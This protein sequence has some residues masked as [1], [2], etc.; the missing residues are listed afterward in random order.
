M[1]NT[2]LL[3]KELQSDG[4]PVP[5]CEI[6]TNGFTRWGHN[7]HMWCCNINDNGWVFG[8]WKTGQHWVIFD[9]TESKPLSKEEKRR[10]AE[11]IEAQKQE[12]QKRTI[13]R[14]QRVATQQ[15]NFYTNCC[16][17]DVP[18][19]FPYLVKKQIKPVYGM[20]YFAIKKQI[21]VPMV[22]V[23]G[24]MWSLQSIDT[25]GGKQFASGGRIKGCFF[26][27]GNIKD[28]TITIVC[29]G[30]AT[31]ISIYT[32]TNIPTIAAM[33]AGNIDSVVSELTKSCSCKQI[34]IAGD[35][36]WEKIPNTGKETAYKV[37][38]KY[39]LKAVLPNKLLSGMSDFNDVFC[40][41]GIEEVK[42]Q[43][44]KGKKTC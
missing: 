6:K 23:Y 30:V 5:D 9:N 41:Y 15:Y 10:V 42:N 18:A 43:I 16:I 37:A 14:Q 7:K 12:M 33:N 17:A 40:H 27:I 25:T 39:A 20:K 19:D 31:G 32:A 2:N 21:I 24:K 29:E 28:S 22:D 8:D 44:M 13:E 35:N 3:I 34:I 1:L 4:L 26:P 36:D 38:Q 11:I